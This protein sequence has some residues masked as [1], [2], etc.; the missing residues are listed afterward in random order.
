MARALASSGLP[1]CPSPRLKN[2]IFD[3]RQASVRSVSATEEDYEH[4]R[5]WSQEDSTT[6]KDSLPVLRH[7]PT[8][9]TVSFVEP[10]NCISG[11]SSRVWYLPGEPSAEEDGEL[12]RQSEVFGSDMHSIE[13]AEPAEIDQASETCSA[14]RADTVSTRTVGNSVY[15]TSAAAGV[16]VHA[17][18]RVSP[19]AVPAQRYS[20]PRPT[21]APLATCDGQRG[22]R[23]WRLR[24]SSTR[25]RLWTPVGLLTVIYLLLIVAWG[26][27]VFILIMGWT[28]IPVLDRFKWIEICSQVR[29]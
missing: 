11:C 21:S 25:D 7:A 28:A 10:D 22:H 24:L 2:P 12:R 14:G 8:P 26:A 4:N 16:P 1:R 23:A 9:R 19:A 3:G 13:Y 27:A 15:D 18:P 6:N 17:A 5:V 29:P 20:F